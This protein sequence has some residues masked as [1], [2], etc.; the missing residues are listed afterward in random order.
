L[1]D[2]FIS[3]S[4]D[5]RS[6]AEELTQK[7]ES[8]GVAVWIDYK[9]ASWGKPFP[10]S[11]EEGLDQTRHIICLMSPSWTSSAWSRIERYSAMVDD[12]DGFLGKLLPILLSHETAIPRFMK[13][14]VYKDFTKEGAIAKEYPSIRDHIINSR[15][16][17]RHSVTGSKPQL[18]EEDG[19]HLP[20]LGFVFVV[21]HPA[22]GKS[23]FCRF[24]KKYLAARG[25][26]TKKQSD[27]LYLQALFRLD[28]ARGNRNRFE[29]DPH[30][31]FK[32]K[33]PLVYDEVLRLIHD[34]IISSHVSPNELRVI[35]FSRPH[36]DSCFLYY[37][38]KALVNSAIV[39]VDT[40]LE[41]CEAR[42]KQR[43]AELAKR[44]AGVEPD[45]DAFDFDPDI[46][47][48]PPNVYERYRRAASEWDNQALALALMP[49]RG[50]FHIDNSDDDLVEYQQVCKQLV[51][52]L[53]APLIDVPEQLKEF[54][55]RRISALETFV[56]HESRPAIPPNNGIDSDD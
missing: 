35:E 16:T 48:T 14:L 9:D 44:M 25:I 20:P 18:V 52:Q 34:E 31:E 30:S 43:R 36:Y 21:G 53:L 10:A 29:A 4:H 12:P 8:D 45:A 22:A 47:F 38:M 32:V 39:H 33:D 2:V 6:V 27:Y 26:T 55:Q 46:H 17:Q 40:P 49:S 37:T 7:L 24:L 1:K 56:S 3:Y 19:T 54:Y 41:I 23:T 5:D 51:N 11:I 13:P 28:T 42:N 50:Y 15:S